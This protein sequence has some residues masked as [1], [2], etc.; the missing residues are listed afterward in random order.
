MIVDVPPESAPSI[1]DAAPG[2]PDN[3]V[4]ASFGQQSEV[5]QERPF[6][7]SHHS[8][9]VAPQ[10]RTVRCG[11]CGAQLE[12]F[13]VLLQYANKERR[14]RHWE[15]ETF[16]KHEELAQL[17]AE[18]RKAKARL[19]YALRGDPEFAATEER[20]RGERLRHQIIEATRDMSQTCRRLE[21][22]VQ[23]RRFT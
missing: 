23:R 2:D 15:A 7:C 13:D 17:R 4:Y 1:G 6:H 11:A 18:E 12:A 22:L 10:D 20:I 5:R 21:R 9:V 8:Y 3:V 14:W 16:R 19:K